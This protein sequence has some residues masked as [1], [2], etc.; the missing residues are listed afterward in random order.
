MNKYSGIIPATMVLI[1]VSGFAARCQTYFTK[2]EVG[3]AV[4]V[5][6]YF[7]DLND[8]YGF[9]T[10]G[11]AGGVYLRRKLSN[12]I[13]VK[14]GAFYT[15]VGYDDKY[16]KDSY[17]NERNL[18]FRSDVIEASF[19]AEFNFFR[20]IT[21]DKNFRFTP[22]LTGGIGEFYYN[23]YTTYQGKKYYLQPQGTEGQNAGYGDRK[24]TNFSTC[25]PIGVGVKFW[26]M[27]GMN[28]SFEIADRLTLTDYLDDVS[29]TYVGINKF[30]ERQLD[31]G[32][33]AGALQ[34]RSVELDPNNPLGRP[35]K[36]RGN[37]ASYDQYLI[38]MFSI[39]WHFT[40][41][42]CPQNTDDDMIRTY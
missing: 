32:P 39:S 27:P 40:T 35:G 2:T 6:Q 22:Y 38:G 20:F 23:P 1:A 42:R 21:G 7:G 29:T 12:Y 31:Q 17:E 9:K 26:I 33:V 13:A 34:D 36:Q 25:F 11:P 15:N 4:G 24:Y 37:T 41:Y 16:N 19:Q 28:F 30:P 3:A 10:I 18:N 8:R 5:S 14:F